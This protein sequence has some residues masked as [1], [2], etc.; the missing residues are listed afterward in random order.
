MQPL[1]KAQLRVEMRRF[2]QDL[3][4]GISLE[5]FAEICGMCKDTLTKVFIQETRPL[6]EWVQ[7]RV[8]RGYA[9]W[10][11]GNIRTMRT[12]T[13]RLYGDYRKQPIPPLVEHTGLVFQ[14]GSFK[15]K[16]GLKNRH[17]YSS[18]TLDEAL[19]G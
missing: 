10:K 19:K 9:E 5:C 18:P 4:R 3:D 14:D 8:N 12:N 2:I 1:S 7:I 13:G 11:R 6:S 17:D 16:M 15:I